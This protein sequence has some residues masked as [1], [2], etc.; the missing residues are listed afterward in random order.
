CMTVTIRPTS[1]TVFLVCKRLTPSVIMRDNH[2][3]R[4]QYHLLS[5]AAWGVLRAVRRQKALQR[6]PR[7][8]TAIGLEARLPLQPIEIAIELGHEGEREPHIDN[9]R[10]RAFGTTYRPLGDGVLFRQRLGSS[11]AAHGAA[12]LDSHAQSL[13]PGIF[14]LY[15]TTKIIFVV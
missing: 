15:Y 2:G 14:Y 12:W 10:W 5:L 7:D 6:S 13:H 8:H 1:T 4:R 11:Q 9:R 3:Y